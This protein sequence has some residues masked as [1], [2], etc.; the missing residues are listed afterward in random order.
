V[1]PTPGRGRRIRQRPAHRKRVSGPASPTSSGRRAAT[2][3]ERDT[4]L[5]PPTPR[6]PATS[7]RSALRPGEPRRH[8]AHTNNPK[9]AS[10][11]SP[12]AASPRSSQSA[13]CQTPSPKASQKRPI[14]ETSPTCAAEGLRRFVGPRT[15]RGGARP[16]AHAADAH[17][18]RSAALVSLLVSDGLRIAEVLACDIKHFSRQRGHRVLRSRAQSAPRRGRFAPSVALVRARLRG[19]KRRRRA[20]RLLCRTKSRARASRPEAG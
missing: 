10:Y 19:R 11:D 7:R 14:S 1:S 5:S 6:S 9:I 16:P 8:L 4:S 17:G 2:C 13:S 15:D 12:S 3:R 20:A 18:P